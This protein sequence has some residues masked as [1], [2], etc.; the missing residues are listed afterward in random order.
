MNLYHH[1][2]HHDGLPAVTDVVDVGEPIGA[3]WRRHLDAKKRE[4][5]ECLVRLADLHGLKLA[6]FVAAPVAPVRPFRMRNGPSI[7]W[8]LAVRIHAV[9]AA[10]T[11][12]K[13][14]V[15][16]LCLMGGFDWSEVA[17]LWKDMSKRDPVLLAK[18]AGD[19]AP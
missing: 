11:N 7:P 17:A 4:A 16:Q 2:S 15:E 19:D 6:D 1:V 3:P 18:L 8:E 13:Q 10:M 14:T 5:A 12:S 9:W